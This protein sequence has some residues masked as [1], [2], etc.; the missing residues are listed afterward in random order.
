MPMSLPIYSSPTNLSEYERD[1]Y[2]RQRAFEWISAHPA[3]FVVN[4]L[5]KIA[6]LY[7]FDPLSSRS[8]MADLYRVAGFFPYGLLLPFILLGSVSC[9]RQPQFRILYWHILFVTG[10]A[11]VFFGDSRLR[12][13]I[14]P[15]LYLF[16]ALGLQRAI[17]W[18]PKQRGRST[19]N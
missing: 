4:G 15:H 11:F 10:L 14:Q 12:T 17:S 3:S 18:W 8:A 6:A 7:S 2:F 13:A 16:G 19:V 9:L 1:Q 5:R